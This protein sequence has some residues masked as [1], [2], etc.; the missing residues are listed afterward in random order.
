MKS[1]FK[2]YLS[3]GLYAM[4]HSLNKE[5]EEELTKAKQKALNKEDRTIA[6]KYLDMLK[7][8]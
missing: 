4:A 2:D 1:N 8:K 3:L 6:E 5:A 7:E